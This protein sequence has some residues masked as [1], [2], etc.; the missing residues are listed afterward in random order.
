MRQKKRLYQAIACIL[1]CFF[2]FQ[3]GFQRESL[4]VYASVTKESIRAKERQITAAKKDRESLKNNKT[5]LEKLKKQL[6][7]QKSDL[8]AYISNLDASLTSIQKKIKD[9]ESSIASKQAEI[10]ETQK[11][12]E[13][14]KK[15][16]KKQYEDMKVRI[17]F[18]YEKGDTYLLELVMS[19]QTFGDMLNKAE[20]VSQVSSY[21]QKK[22]Q[23]YAQTTQ[24]IALSEKALKEEH[25]TLEAAKNQLSSEQASMQSLMQDKQKQLTAVNSDI[26]NKEAAIAEYE[27]QIKEEND[28]IAALEKALAAD[29]ASLASRPKYDGGMFTWPCPGYTRI[30]DNFGMRMH[31]TLKINKMHN[32]IDLAAPVGSSILAAYKGRV[33]AASYSSTMG[34]YIMIDHGGGLYTLYMHCSAL[35]V[36]Q[37]TEVKAGQN[38]AAVGSTGRSTG[39]HLH[40]G[41]R[42]NGGYVSPWNYLKG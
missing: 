29:K 3:A 10:E 13:E 30:S 37:G 19:S 32:G 11:Q 42:L 12:L 15:I 17:R 16:Q 21:D 31:P 5:D 24:L 38:I 14:A 2:C 27:A 22:L 8:N 40:F 33:V 23:E 26:S 39:P 6:E 25:E 18:M 41:V 35:Y 7:G 20:Y 4:P 1:I 34:N 9:L 36:S 28:T